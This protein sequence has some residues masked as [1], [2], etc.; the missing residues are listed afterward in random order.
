MSS[1]LRF[2]TSAPFW[3]GVVTTFALASCGGDSGSPAAPDTG[4][5]NGSGGTP[6]VLPD[7]PFGAVIAPIFEAR[8]CTAS[9]CHGIPNQADLRL[10][11]DTAWVELVNVQAVME[12][13]EVLVR[14]ESIRLLPQ[15]LPPG[16]TDEIFVKALPS[17]HPLAFDRQS[18]E[19]VGGSLS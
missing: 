9:S 10:L 5:P 16:S 15:P 8:G 19:P 12:P 11:A 2:R 13:Q 7:P 4:G 1:T 17:Y 6:S 18:E 3:V 14:V